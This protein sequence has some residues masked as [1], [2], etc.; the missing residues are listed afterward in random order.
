MTS[1]TR[2]LAAWS[3]LVA[4]SGSAVLAAAPS[5]SPFSQPQPAFYGQVR[6]RLELNHKA[7][8]DTS[9]SAAYTLLR[10]RLGF[11]AVTSEFS[12]VKIELQDA[13]VLGNEPVTGLNQSSTTTGNSK[14]VDLTQGYGALEYL[15]GE[16]NSLKAA[17]GRMKMSLGAGRYLSTLEWSPTARPFDGFATNLRIDKLN[18]TGFGF[19][20]RD[21]TSYANVL[22]NGVYNQLWGAYASLPLSDSATIEAGAFYDMGRQANL[23]PL[24]PDTTANHDIATLDGRAVAKFGPVAIEQEILYQTGEVN[25]NKK[26]DVDVAAWYTS[27]RIGV[28]LP[29]GKLNLGL[30][31]MS[32][33]GDAKDME[34]NQYRA[35]YWFAHS[36]FGWM[37]YFLNNPKYGVVDYRVDADVPVGEFA[38]VKAQY[39]YFTPQIATD[40]GAKLKAYGQ[41]I[42]AEIHV[43]RIPKTLLVLGAGVFLPGDG[44]Y[45][46][47]GALTQ[48]ASSAVKTGPGYFVYFQ[49]AFNF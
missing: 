7:L 33:D 46:L 19:L 36:Y 20:V 23:V 24:T 29:M 48:L 2:A 47:P 21:T 10:S 35:Q 27:T 5:E 28:V 39:H 18:V 14:G 34:L 6:P 44:A 49:P 40:N 45:L 30:D 25:A 22:A 41:E 37:D 26:G 15:F 12:E 1:S 17:F 3:S 16:S 9:H 38:S 11:M 13:R 31:A 43:T 8:A 32:G 42:D 4:A